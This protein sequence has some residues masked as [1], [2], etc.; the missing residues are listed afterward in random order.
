MRTGHIL[1][2]QDSADLRLE[3][4]VEHPIGLIKDKVANVRKSEA[5]VLTVDQIYEMI[6]SCARWPGVRSCASPY[7][8]GVP[9]WEKCYCR[10]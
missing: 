7:N 6:K 9:E 2:L 5:G 3:T 1:A 10:C 4:H 8:V